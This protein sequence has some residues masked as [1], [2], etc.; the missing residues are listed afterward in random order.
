MAAIAVFGADTH[1]SEAIWPNKPKIRNDS[2][3]GLSQLVDLAI[4][5]Q[6]PLVLAGDCLELLDTQTP[7]SAT[8]KFVQN[9]IERLR[10][11]NQRLYYVSGQHDRAK[12]S[13]LNAIHDWA[14]DV[15]GRMFQL[16]EHVW[17]GVD[18]QENRALE[19]MLA[20]KPK[21]YGLVCHQRWAEF[22]G[23]R[24]YQGKL[25]D[26]QECKVLITGDM[27]SK[28]YK[29]IG[30]MHAFSPGATH[31]RQVSEP[32]KHFAMVATDTGEFQFKRIKSR[33]TYRA[34]I[35]MGVDVRHQ[36]DRIVQEVH[37]LAT[38][39]E[40]M[41]LPIE[42]QQP[43]VIFDHTGHIDVAYERLADELGDNAHVM[44]RGKG[45]A[46]ELLDAVEVQP[47]SVVNRNDEMIDT[48]Y[49]VVQAR[50]AD[51]D[52]VRILSYAQQGRDLKELTE[53]I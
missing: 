14:T 8:V 46:K 35:T 21:T 36:L 49:R 40:N 1:V 38:S 27:H 29:K 52:V 13:W 2:F 25:V 5:V 18:Y 23:G 44:T 20:H 47:T 42:L 45:A 3:F 9:Q 7:T 19:L 53:T 16:G 37:D 26:V 15:S 41:S 24:N 48:Y 32:D 4:E 51:P 34:S 31:K 50:V 12:P 22:G 28:I 39:A 30:K 17:Y 10:Q 11:A 6:A 43:F 33:L